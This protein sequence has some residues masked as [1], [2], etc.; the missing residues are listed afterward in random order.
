MKPILKIAS[1]LIVGSLALVPAGFC[2]DNAHAGQTPRTPS[3]PK[4][5]SYNTGSYTGNTMSG[6]WDKAMNAQRQ[7]SH[8]SS[9]GQV[10]ASYPAASSV[11]KV[12]LIKTPTQ[13]YEGEHSSNP[14]SRPVAS[15]PIAVRQ[16]Q[17]ALQSAQLAV[18]AAENNLEEPE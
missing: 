2:E 8:F 18:P 3:V 16:A 13:V 4:T 15:E 11:G 7:A 12:P 14:L 1:Y 5:P 9:A 10:P 17:Q 6:N